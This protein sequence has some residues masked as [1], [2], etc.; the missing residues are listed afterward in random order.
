M[1]ISPSVQPPPP[2]SAGASQLLATLR[3]TRIAA[4]TQLAHAEQSFFFC[5]WIAR[6]VHER[7][8][9][10]S[11]AVQLCNPNKMEL[12]SSSSNLHILFCYM[13]YAPDVSHLCALHHVSLT[14]YVP[15]QLSRRILSLLGESGGRMARTHETWVRLPVAPSNQKLKLFLF[16]FVFLNEAYPLAPTLYSHYLTHRA[17]GSAPQSSTEV[18]L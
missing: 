16:L 5:G 12:R 7:Q 10:L 8:E 15:Q 4:M 2:L 18:P 9:S 14:G 11:T 13:T 6:N 1:G 3:E 17:I